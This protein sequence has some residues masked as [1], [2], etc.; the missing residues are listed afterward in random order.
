MALDVEH[1]EKVSILDRI[2]EDEREDGYS[3]VQ[4]YRESLGGQ[5][6]SHLDAELAARSRDVYSGA[7]IGRYGDEMPVWVFLEVVS[8]GTLVD[9]CSF[10]SGRWGDKELLDLHY[11]MK[12]AKS[13]RNA[14]S[15]GAC[16]M[17][18]FGDVDGKA[19]STPRTVRNALG[20]TGLSKQVR[21]R[22]LG[23]PRMRD[24]VTLAFL[25]SARVPEGAAKRGARTAIASF[26]DG[27]AERLSNIP[28]NN[29]AVAGL[30]FAKS[31]TEE[32]SLI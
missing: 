2:A 14:A 28:S 12:K 20:S 19:S 24:I 4:D 31:L 8:F 6:L 23:N 9:F 27:A 30:A 18:G 13:I 26:F 16:I 21:S 3:I 29:P 25:C 32:L 5:R 1:Y 11:M 22:W 15:H 10:C 17:N 7:V